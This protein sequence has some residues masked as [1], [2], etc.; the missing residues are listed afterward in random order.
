MKLYRSRKGRDDFTQDTEEIK[1][2]KKSDFPV[3]NTAL[4]SGAAEEKRRVRC[5]RKRE[6]GWSNWVSH[7]WEE[8]KRVSEK[9]H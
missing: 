8:D 3:C 2:K 6:E 7:V 5:K 4:L 9:P 1:E